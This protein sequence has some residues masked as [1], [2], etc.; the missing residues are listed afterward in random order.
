VL[1]C[2]GAGLFGLTVMAYGGLVTYAI[3]TTHL[4]PAVQGCPSHAVPLR[5]GSKLHDHAEITVGSDRGGM[6]TGCWA[7]YD[8]PASSTAQDVF[9][10]YAR[11]ENVP[12]WKL[13]ESYSNTGYLAFRSTTV[14]RLQADVGVTTMKRYLTFGPSEV[15]YAVSVCLCDPRS[16]AQ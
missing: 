14:P 2:A 10:Y 8:V 3:L 12:G 1:L 6:T 15:T 4:A 7:T 11:P 5:P 13:A 9:N 16:M